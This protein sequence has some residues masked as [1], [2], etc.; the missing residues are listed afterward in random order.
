VPKRQLGLYT[1][2]E[3]IHEDGWRDHSSSRIKRFYTDLGYKDDVREFHLNL[4]A[5]SNTLGVIGPTPVEE[6]ARR[7]SSVYTFPQTTENNMLMVG[8]NGKVSLNDDWAVQ[9]NLMCVISTRNMSM[10]TPPMWPHVQAIQ[11]SL[12]GRCGRAERWERT[13]SILEPA[14]WHRFEPGIA[15]SI[16]RTHVNSDTVGASLQTT[17]D[18]SLLML[19]NHFVAGANIDYSSL[20]F[21]GSNELG[22]IADTR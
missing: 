13:K 16:D 8:L 14:A 4:S 2:G 10:A 21:S 6:L 18:G 19:N 11:R 20:S 17:Y 1:S 15:G 5:A 12:P 22:T 3:E 9:S 7:Y